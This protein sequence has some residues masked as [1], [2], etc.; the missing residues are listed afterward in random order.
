MYSPSPFWLRPCTVLPSSEPSVQ[1]PPTLQQLRSTR[2]ADEMAFAPV[3]DAA[4]VLVAPVGLVLIFVPAVLTG[5]DDTEP[6]E[7]PTPAEV[8]AE[9][10]TTAGGS[11]ASCRHGERAPLG[12]VTIRVRG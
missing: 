2:I 5:G 3:G 9:P 6:T 10:A 4:G 11:S 12:S 7:E 8:P 1:I